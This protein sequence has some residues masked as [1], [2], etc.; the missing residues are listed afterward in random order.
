MLGALLL[1]IILIFM[2][3]IFA[4]AEIAVLS[5]SDTKLTKMSE[6]GNKKAK[7][8]LSLTKNS[9]KFLSTIQV[10]IT[11]AGFLGSAYA[12]DNFAEPLVSVL[13]S[14]GLTT[15]PTDVLNSICVLIITVILSFFS[16]VFGELVPKRVAMKNP[17]KISLSLVGI[18]KFVSLIFAPFVW[19]L[20][21]STNAI[22]RIFGIDP[23]DQEEAASEEEIIMMLDTSSEMGAIDEQENEMIQNIFRFDDISASEACTHR[24]DVTFLYA[25]DGLDDWRKT[26]SE[27]NYMYYPVCGESSD[28]IIGILSI[29]RFF[30][31]DFSSVADVIE[32]AIEKP[33]Y[34]PANTKAD[35]LFERM[36]KEKNYF[37]VVVD[38]YGGTSGVITSSDLISLIVGDINN[39]SDGEEE[40][41]SLS[42]NRWQI[43]GAALIDDV[44]DALDVEFDTDEFD[45]FGGY[46]FGLV[47]SVPDDGSKFELETDDLII[48]VI[49]VED[50]R[51]LKVI[52]DKKVKESEDE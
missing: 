23:N 21:V 38:E 43:S 35:V 52:V 16:I 45:T 47:G 11:F 34:I 50:H 12:A 51:I 5:V 1:Q 25:D 49:S 4:C 14:A 18:L 26:I 30:S 3:A 33:F 9:S 37:A 19:I 40:I 39:N 28:D 22:L 15:F 7:K 31:G 36:K 46:I 8:L 10:A 27:T 24:K 29:R 6:D 48:N 13:V 2:N 17:E 42:E 32:N 41:R 20:S 44:A